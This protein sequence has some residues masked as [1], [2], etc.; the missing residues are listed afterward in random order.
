[1]STG[2]AS[3]GC[4]STGC[5]STGC[6]STGLC[7]SRSVVVFDCFTIIAL[8]IEIIPTHTYT[9]KYFQFVVV[10]LS[11]VF[12]QQSDPCSHSEDIQRLRMVLRNYLHISE[13]NRNIVKR[14]LVLDTERC[15][16]LYLELVLHHRQPRFIK[17]L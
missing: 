13:F 17:K 5:A 16:V 1:M 3:T 7:I 8:P 12:Y 10:F 2:C 6:A 15:P 14:L 4:A 11:S 9:F